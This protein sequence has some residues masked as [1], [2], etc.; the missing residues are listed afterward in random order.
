M[1]WLSDFVV[2]NGQC[3]AHNVNDQQS[4]IVIKFAIEICPGLCEEPLKE[5]GC[6][7]WTETGMKELAIYQYLTVQHMALAFPYKA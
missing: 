4:E 5:I 7:C 3:W 2:L 1:Y 6:P